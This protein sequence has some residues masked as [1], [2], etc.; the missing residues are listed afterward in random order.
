MGLIPK[1]VKRQE[2]K[3]AQEKWTKPVQRA[4]TYVHNPQ[5]TKKG[6]EEG[7]DKNGHHK[8]RVGEE[9]AV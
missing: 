1:R 3:H 7:R 8:Q 4:L 6:E 2:N 5:H 9:K